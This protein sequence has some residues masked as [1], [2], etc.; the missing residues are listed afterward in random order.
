MTATHVDILEWL[1]DVG[2]DARRTYTAALSGFF[3]YLQREGFRID[4]PA[5]RVP[6]PPPR[7]R[8]PKPISDEDALH[9]WT[10]APAGARTAFGLALLCG[11][12][13]QEISAA[14]WEDVEWGKPPTLLVS[15][16]GAKGGHER[17]VVIPA[18]L[19]A[20]LRDHRRKSGWLARGPGGQGSTADLMGQWLRRIMQ[21]E[22]GVLASPHQC[23]HWYAT[24]MLRRGASVRV[25]QDALG[26]SNLATTGLYLKVTISDQAAI[27]ADLRP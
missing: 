8:L 26:H 21:N 9:I 16:E 15:A 5:D 17:R 22:L 18:T 1:P 25:V 13:V 19:V 11:L 7:R 4:N 12:R 23:R 6:R 3:T 27:V 2:P 20:H 10:A 24:T 14:R